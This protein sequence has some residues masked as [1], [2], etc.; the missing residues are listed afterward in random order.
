ME[1][2]DEELLARYCI[3]LA[4]F[5]DFGRPGAAR[6]YASSP[7]LGVGSAPTIDGLLDIAERHWVDALRRLSEAFFHAFD[8]RFS[9]DA[10]LNPTFQ[11]SGDVGG[12]DADIIIDR[13]LM[14]FKTTVLGRVD[15]V[16]GLYQLIG[17]SLLDYDDEYGIEKLGFYMARQGQVIEWPI[18]DL[19][20]RLTG[21]GS[22]S[23]QELRRDFRDR[24]TGP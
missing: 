11:G 12:A 21:Q 15:K 17:Y 8:G 14:E 6:A 4:L 23:L 13:W 22:P 9:D 2:G 1:P 18:A 5:E 20:E 10:V 7:L 19:F 3:V 24:I 16:R